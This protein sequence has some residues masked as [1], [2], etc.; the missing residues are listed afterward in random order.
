MPVSSLISVQNVSMRFS[1]GDVAT[2]ALSDVSLEIMP[3]EFVSFLGPSGCGKST[4]LNIVAGL[5]RQTEGVVLYEGHPLTGANTHV[6]YMTQGDTLLPWRTVA[7]NLRLPLEIR[8]IT[9]R[10]R[11]LRLAA[12]LKSVSLSGFERQFPHELSGGMRKR[13]Q[14][15]RSMIYDA[16]CLLMDEPFGALDAQLRLSM[17][18]IL[19]TLWIESRK[20]IVFVTHDIDEAIMLSDRIVL[21]SA[22]P[23]RIKHIETID[24]PR[25]RDVRRGR[26]EARFVEY[27]QRLF[28]LLDATAEGDH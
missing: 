26:Y 22:R 11:D 12:A 5:A 3:G 4:L 25:P 27:Q 2:T 18:D 17:H 20:S 9:G 28:D 6:G 13:L 23:G 19:Q 7:G 16:E 14:L 1:R 10:E 24:L 15:A 8:S 21:M